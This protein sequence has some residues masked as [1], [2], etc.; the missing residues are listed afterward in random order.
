MGTKNITALYNGS[1]TYATSISPALSQIINKAATTLALTSSAN[2]SSL[3]QSVT[4][5]G[6]CVAAVFRDPSWECYLQAG[7]E[8]FGNCDA[9]RWIRL[10]HYQHFAERFR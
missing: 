9:E 2:P 7:N 5:Y 6:G 8:G 3:G 1:A 4:F 10:V